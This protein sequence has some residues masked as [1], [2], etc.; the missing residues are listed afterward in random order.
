[1]NT[2]NDDIEK[3]Y[4]EERSGRLVKSLKEAKTC[5]VSPYVYRIWIRGNRIIGKELV[6][7]YG[8]SVCSIR[9]ADA[10]IA[11]RIEMANR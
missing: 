6:L 1:M 8:T 3:L 11:K 2:M 7:A 4:L 9:Q 5:H 10:Y